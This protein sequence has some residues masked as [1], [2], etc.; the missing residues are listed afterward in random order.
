HLDFHADMETYFD[1]KAS[2]FSPDR[3]RT[4]VIN[5]DDAHGRKL[6]GQT[7][8]PK[9]L[10]GLDP[11]ADMVISG[12]Q[13]DVDGTRFTLTGDDVALE[14]AVPLM[15]NFNVSNAA[16]AA[17][18]ALALGTP[19]EAVVR[20]LAAVG[21]IRGRME[22]VSHDGGFTVLVDY[23][24]TP[25][26]ISEVLQ[27]GR[28]SAT[29]RVIAVIGAAGDRDRDK[30][31]LM[32]A[33]AVRFA[34]VTIITSDNPRTEDPGVI[35]EEVK[36]GADAVP[37]STA[38][39]IVDRRDAIFH[40]VKQA[41]SGDIVLILGKGHEQGIEIHGETHPFDDRLVAAEALTSRGLQP[42]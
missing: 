13:G 42:R 10:V 12:I 6:A 1:A 38:R 28:T 33:A 27:A 14:I 18:I 22:P 34:D 31:A 23:A 37:G 25:D 7:E 32:G 20:G 24:H 39:V 11:D 4:A 9:I 8:L 35:A 41:R 29:G 2:L 3:V 21:P 19:A 16:I 26:A 17:T 30:R 15:G 36:R 5:I 40:A